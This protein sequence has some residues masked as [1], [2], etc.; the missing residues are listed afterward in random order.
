VD[1][2]RGSGEHQVGDSQPHREH[3]AAA[4]PGGRGFLRPQ[5]RGRGG[6]RHAWFSPGAVCVG[7]YRI[8]HRAGPAGRS[9]RTHHTHDRRPQSRQIDPA[10]GVPGLASTLAFERL[11][12]SSA[13]GHPQAR[14]LKSWSVSGDGL[15]WRL[16]LRPGVKFQDGSPLTA[17][18]VKRTFDAAMSDP[19]QPEPDGLPAE[20]SRRS[21]RP[22][23]ARWCSALRAGARTSWTTSTA[24]SAGRPPTGR[25]GWERARS[26]SPPR[27]T[28]RDARGQ[29][30]L[31]RRASRHRSG[32][33][34]AVRPRCGRRG[35][36]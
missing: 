12:T 16:L 1:D 23:T 32:R 4:S 10:H 19:K 21:P 31:L 24:L 13:E 35:P 11:S 9:A 30:V 6:S 34:Q 3:A 33:R 2:Y 20:R 26:P 28:T 7:L 36:A 17:D 29:P 5:V 15:T 14:L 25:R 18:D 22:A 8:L 27:R